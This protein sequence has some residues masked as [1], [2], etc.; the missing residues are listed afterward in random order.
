[1]KKISDQSKVIREQSKIIS[2]LKL[3]KL[4]DN[5]E[6]NSKKLYS[7]IVG[8]S[9][10][11]AYQAEKATRKVRKKVQQRPNGPIL[12]V[13]SKSGANVDEVQI[14]VKNNLNPLTDPMMSLRQTAKVTLS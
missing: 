3:S 1:M 12:V 10:L 4:S 11:T 5:L 9:S 8:D 6:R 14:I 13:K 7:H 2:E